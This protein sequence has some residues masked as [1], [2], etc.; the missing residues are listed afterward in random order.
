MKD[1]DRVPYIQ[2]KRRIKNNPRERFRIGIIRT[3][4][5][6]L[7]VMLDKRKDNYKKLSER[8]EIFISL[9]EKRNEGIKQ[10]LKGLLIAFLMAFTRRALRKRVYNKIL[11]GG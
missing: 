11:R 3:I 9:S 2:L 10:R 7:V 4:L 5:D 8:F 6:H 1:Q